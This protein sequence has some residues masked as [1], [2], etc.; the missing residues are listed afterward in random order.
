VESV[1]LG[2]HATLN[3]LVDDLV[4]QKAIGVAECEYNA[5]RGKIKTKQSKS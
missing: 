2:T 4:R 1:R 5:N 3:L